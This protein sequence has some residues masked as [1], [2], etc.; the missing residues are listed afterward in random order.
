M[1]RLFVGLVLSALLPCFAVFLCSCTVVPKKVDVE[2]VQQDA[3]SPSQYGNTGGFLGFKDHRGLYT[4]NA[5]A[6]YNILIDRYRLQLKAKEA[7]E[8]N[9]NDGVRPDVDKYGN[10][11]FSMD[12]EHM[13]YFLL[14][15]GYLRDRE[16]A[17]S[18]TSKIADKL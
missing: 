16:K 12:K 1:K 5:I 18:L 10:N 11:V 8:I 13:L 17:D 14:M 15:R 2:E 3:S 6:R 7:V 4:T 9:P